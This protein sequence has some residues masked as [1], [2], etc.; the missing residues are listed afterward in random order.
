M[1]AASNLAVGVRSLAAGEHSPVVE[2]VAVHSPEV[3]GRNPEAA[4]RNLEAAARYRVD[5]MPLRRRSKMQPRR[6]FAGCS[7]GSISY[8]FSFQ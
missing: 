4:G 8:D 6:R 1:E 2:V 5:L 3:A 7:W